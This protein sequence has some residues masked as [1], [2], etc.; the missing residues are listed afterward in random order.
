MEEDRAPLSRHHRIV[1]VTQH[2]DQIVEVVFAPKLLGAG[3]IGQMH[4][5]V[6]GAVTRRVAPTVVGLGDEGGEAG[7]GSCQT[8]GAIAQFAQGKGADRRA[9]IAFA[10][11]VSSLS[12]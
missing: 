1:V 7:R 6:I 8:V 5:T 2:H 4:R 9:A 12:P 3:R 10:R 11:T